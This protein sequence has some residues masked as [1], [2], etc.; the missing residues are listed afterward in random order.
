[1]LQP[2][3]PV[4]DWLLPLWDSFQSQYSEWATLQIGKFLAYPIN[5]QDISRF[6]NRDINA[7]MWVGLGTQERDLFDINV[8]LYTPVEDFNMPE[9]DMEKYHDLA[10]LN[11][12]YSLKSKDQDAGCS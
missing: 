6:V 12:A 10:N 4:G 7:K 2:V 5:M 3:S 11:I 9:E 8:P 1:M